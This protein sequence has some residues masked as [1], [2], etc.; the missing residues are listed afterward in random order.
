VS[1]SSDDR[2]VVTRRDFTLESAL[3]L[4]A[5]VTITI[6]GCGDDDNN[7]SPAPTAPGPTPVANVTGSVS[8]NHGHTAS[9]TGAQITSGGALALDIRGDATHPHTI[10]VSSA[11]LQSIGARQ[12]VAI[13]SST[14]NNHSHTVTF[15]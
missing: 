1:E 6:T 8:A 3:A 11:Q 12:Q 10:Q 4:L 15:N 2:H 5:G 14:D 13:A 7:S 9:I